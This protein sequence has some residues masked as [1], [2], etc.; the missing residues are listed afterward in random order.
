MKKFISTTAFV[1]LFIGL[2]LPVSA[3]DFS[4]IRLQGFD[5]A[6]GGT[7]DWTFQ[8]Q[9]GSTS[10]LAFFVSGTPLS[11]LN[12]MADAPGGAASLGA[13][14]LG[15]GFGA[16][17]GSGNRFA[18]APLHVV[19][20]GG[21]DA[22]SL[23]QVFIDDRSGQAF[24]RVLRM[25]AANSL[26]MD[27]TDTMTGTTF[28]MNN[29]TG[30]FYIME[31]SNNQNI[32]FFIGAQAPHNLFNLDPAGGVG[33]NTFG[34]NVAAM[35][36]ITADGA[37]GML[38]TPETNETPVILADASMLNDTVN[39]TMAEFRNNGQCDQILIDTSAN[40]GAGQTWR[41]R[42]QGDRVTYQDVTGYTKANMA[43]FGD[44]AVR[45]SV[46]VN[47]QNATPNMTV[48]PNG[49][50]NIIGQPANTVPL[51]ENDL[52]QGF[53]PKGG[54]LNVNGNIFARG[55]ITSDG[56]KTSSDRNKKENI[57]PVDVQQV[58]KKVVDLP[59]ATWNYKKDEGKT[60][61]MGPMAQDF[62]QAFQLGDDNK[63]IFATDKDGVALAAIQGLHQIV[64]SKD[65]Q[66][67][68]LKE[69][70]ESQAEMIDELT[71]RLER[72]EAMVAPN[73]N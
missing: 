43:V 57:R 45:Y 54:N 17:A 16:F 41:I 14:G 72:L 68:K 29:D 33:I 40:G 48:R 21:E 4:Q 13:S 12:L 37:G 52:N 62:F 60:P 2:V 55:T 44:G 10:N 19:G 64:K 32:P 22:F 39:R 69:T 28:S 27:M 3:Q 5:G 36:H 26:F 15:I 53:H 34:G 1:I 11:V 65:N 8:P 70:T 7:P 35:L 24:R 9:G 42:T 47:N 66:I 25:Q 51:N 18:Q 58:L 67:S 71:A 30:A 73:Q 38:S 46:G 56:N 6:G 63:T 59:I 20:G 23:G 50:V 49:D 61:H 31:D